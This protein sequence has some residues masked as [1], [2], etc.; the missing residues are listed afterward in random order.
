[1]LPVSRSAR[2]SVNMGSHLENTVSSVLAITCGV[3]AALL[4]SAVAYAQ[5]TPTPGCTDDTWIATST[6]NAASA[7]Y[8]HTAVWTGNEM[9]VWGGNF[10][11]PLGFGDRYNPATDS[12]STISS[13][14]APIARYSHTAIWTGGEMIVWGGFNNGNNFNTGGRYNPGTDAWTVTNTINAPMGRYSHAA[15]WTGSE[16]IVWGGAFSDGSGIHYLNTGGRYDPDSD[17]WTATSTTNAPIPLYK[18]TA[19]WTGSEM[20]V[21]GG[22]DGTPHNTG[23]RYNPNTDSWVAT[24][25]VNAPAARYRDTAIWTGTEMIVWGGGNDGANFNTGGKYNPSTD[26]WVAMSTTNAPTRRYDHTAVWTGS[27]MIVSSGNEDGGPPGLNTGG[28][29]NPLTHTWSPTTR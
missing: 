2:D 16:M 12:W 14:N 25:T 7:R 13:T 17:S 4:M 6:A 20:I 1:M 27:E 24:S 8:V 28:S 18:H 5:P 15:V 22:Y 21:W 19:V 29:Y 9:V 11:G 3:T 23:A 26:T 10:A